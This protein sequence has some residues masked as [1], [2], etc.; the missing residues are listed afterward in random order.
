MNLQEISYLTAIW[1]LIGRLYSLRN[2]PV[3]TNVEQYGLGI[4]I[5]TF[6]YKLQPYIFICYLIVNFIHNEWVFP[7]I[8]ILL[9]II[10]GAIIAKLL[11]ILKIIVSSSR[12]ITPPF[13]VVY[14]FILLIFDLLLIIKAL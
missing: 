2:M 11:V 8:N 5:A 14:A 4:G 3:Y 12:D 10:I 6:S 9:A 7:F 1:F 13:I